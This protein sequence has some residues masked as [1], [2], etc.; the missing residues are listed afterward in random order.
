MSLC[1]E[2]PG[3]GHPRKETNGQGS[4][5]GVTRELR[6]RFCDITPPLKNH[7]PVIWSVF[8]VLVLMDDLCDIPGL[9]PAHA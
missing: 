7:V 5:I 4:E 3:S 9:F 6:E 1:L 2:G 8:W